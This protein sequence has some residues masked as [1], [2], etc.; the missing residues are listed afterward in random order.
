MG[1]WRREEKIFQALPD[2]RK[3]NIEIVFSAYRSMQCDKAYLTMPVT[4]GKRYYEVLDR[5]GVKSIDELEKKKP[6]ALREEIIIPNIDEANSFAKLIDGVALPL[7]VPGVF[8]ARKQRWGQDEYMV[9]WLR[10]LTSSIKELWL[11]DDW[12]YSNGGAMEFCRGIMLQ[13]RFIE[14]RTDRFAIYDRHRNP[15]SLVDGAKRLASAI[16]DLT[17]RGYDTAK[18][19]VELSQ[20]AGVAAYLHD[21]STTR[22]EWAAHTDGVP[23]DAYA[24]VQAA[25]S[26]GAPIAFDR[27]F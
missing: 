1:L 2:D 25:Q 6:G 26:V 13:Y 12:E 7:V 27:S 20:L 9:L 8:E 24:V 19:K 21:P 11:I 17:R 18:L 22:R 14:E 10:V 16:S 23:F 15:V 5:H 3:A 4:S